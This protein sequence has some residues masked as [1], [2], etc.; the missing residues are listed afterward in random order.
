M[1]GIA[2]TH[3]P[4][5]LNLLVSSAWISF[6]IFSYDSRHVFVLCIDVVHLVLVESLDLVSNTRP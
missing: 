5:W 6:T 1:S 2:V 3:A 4:I